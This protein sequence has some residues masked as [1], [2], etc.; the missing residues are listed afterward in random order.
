MK[1][2]KKKRQFSISVA[3]T[4]LSIAD[5][6]FS[7]M[8][9]RDEL[10]YYYLYVYLFSKLHSKFYIHILTQNG[11]IWSGRGYVGEPDIDVDWSEVAIFIIH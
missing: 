4:H 3:E 2:S 6:F 10:A 7:I 1:G 9:S 8:Y 11:L 5:V